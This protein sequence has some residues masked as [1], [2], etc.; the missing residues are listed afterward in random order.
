MTLENK[1]ILITGGAG[2][3]GSHLVDRLIQ[4]QSL[5]LV[6][7]D[8]FFLGKESNLEEAKANCLHLKIYQQDASDYEVMEQ[9][10]KNEGIQVVFNLAAIPLEASLTYPRQS[11]EQT[12][13]VTLCLCELARNREFETL[14]HFSS[15]EA[16]GTSLYAPMDENHPLNPR[17]PY[18]ASKAASDHLVFSYCQ[19]FGIDA[20]IIRPFNQYGPRQN[21]GSYA[22][23][24]PL[25][26]KRILSGES[27]IIYGDGEQTRDFLYVTDT[28]DA[29]VQVYNCAQTRGRTINIGSGKE[30]SVNTLVRLIA[31][32]LDCDKPIIY[33]EARPGDVRRHIAGIKLAEELI[34]FRP[35]ID[36]DEGLKKTID[37]YKES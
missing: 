12:V 9:I 37:W 16:Y 23:V 20:S 27:P 25:T 4:E 22:A 28:A 1:S 10:M 13:N 33:Q 19:T 3:I 30:T 14:I 18:A 31:Q 24:I 34:G 36:L 26:I 7:V 11:Y 2:F 15:S 17:T 6:V 5:N 21:E 8:D 32:H 29:A 35:E